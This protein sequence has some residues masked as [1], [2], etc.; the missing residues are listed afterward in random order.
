MDYSGHSGKEGEKQ[1]CLLEK[2]Q[3]LE[4]VTAALALGKENQSA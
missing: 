4:G 3:S 2:K 1:F